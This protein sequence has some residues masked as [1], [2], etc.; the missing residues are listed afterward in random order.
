MTTR[1]LFVCSGNICRS[2]MALYLM[3][4]RVEQLQLP[5]EL[6]SAGTLGIIDRAPPPNALA[7]MR[8]IGV[9]MDDHRSKGVTTELMTWADRVV[10]MTYEHAS[11]LRERYPDAQCDIELLGPYGGKSPEVDDP[12]GRWRGTFRRVRR[13]IEGCIEG[14]VRSIEGP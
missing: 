2:P 6:D 12:M 8:E 3:R 7:V 5:V 4:A 1:V 14:L 11:T 9:S 13:Q 10:V